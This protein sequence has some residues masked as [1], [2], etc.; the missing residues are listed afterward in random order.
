[1]HGTGEG[2]EHR[3]VQESTAFHPGD[4]RMNEPMNDAESIAMMARNISNPVEREAYIQ[5]ACAANQTLLAQVRL[6]IATP[7]QREQEHDLA[8]TLATA[9]EAAEESVTAQ[10]EPSTRPAANLI[11]GRYRLIKKIGE[12][13]M[14]SVWTAEQRQPVTRQVALKLIKKG[15]D[16]A[17][18]LARFD[19]ERQALALMDH[20]NIARIFDG[21]ITESGS[22]FFVMELVQGE[23]IT[24]FCDERRMTPEQRLELFIPVCQAIQHAHHKGII[25]R[26]IKPSNV[27]VTM[28]DD[29]PVPKVIDFGVA[30]ATGPALTDLSLD[31]GLGVV[32]TPQYM[33]PE[34]AS[35][36][37]IDIDTRS[38]V[39]SLGVLLYELLAGSTPFRQEELAKAGFLEILRVIR[40]EDPPRPSTKLSSAEALPSL[41]ASRGTDPKRLSLLLRNELDWIV[42]RSLE[43][44]RSRRYETANAFAADISRYLNGE[45][46]HAHPPS[47]GYRL[48]KFLR[49]NRGGVV[50]AASIA[51]T[52]I[53]GCIGTSL[54]MVEAQRQATLARKESIL[55]EEARQNEAQQRSIADRERELAEQRLLSARQAVSAVVN[56]IP[57][58]LEN[59]PLASG[60][61]RIILEQMNQ[62]LNATADTPE[63]DRQFASSRAWGLLAIETRAAQQAQQSGEYEVAQLHYRNA[64][65]IAQEVYQGN[66]RD[67]AKAAGNLAM[68]YALMAELSSTRSQPDSA[69]FIR[70][71]I[72]LRQEA[73]EIEPAEDSLGKRRASLGNT[74]N[75]LA[76]IRSREVSR[77]PSAEQKSA[78]LETMTIS[79]TALDHLQAAIDQLADSPQEQAI[80]RRDQAVGAI[81]LAGLAK[82]AEDGVTVIEGYELAIG[83]F[84]TLVILEPGR[85]SYRTA[86]AEVHGLYGDYLLVEK[87]DPAAARTHYVES[88]K[89]LREFSSDAQLDWLRWHRTLAYYRLGLTAQAQANNDQVRRYFERASLISDLHLREKSDLVRDPEMLIDDRVQLML[90]QAWAGQAAAAVQIARDIRSQLSDVQQSREK[91]WAAG[92]LAR[93][94]FAIA[95]ASEKGG[96]PD[97]GQKAARSEALLTMQ[98]AMDLGF[99]DVAYLHSDPDVAPLRRIEGFDALL[100]SLTTNQK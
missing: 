36:N 98:Q 14:G 51:G 78:A 48:Q 11:A 39:Y 70:E 60:P 7:L 58:L 43:K 27:L 59:V 67:R 96:L 87:L 2:K 95:I 38:D 72:Q 32:G 3:T 61:Q 54:G 50:A 62:L 16:S 28:V 89:R 63:E 88:M 25:H 18:V 82:L 93:A 53:V 85:V 80:A 10:F 92:A 12:G 31:T 90:E 45:P 6:L 22:P 83:N 74:W 30:K 55:K 77:L 100:Q 52:L 86:L 17:A 26:D 56:N 69:T 37:R 66:P 21:G 15:M 47:M 65:K 91:P 81:A 42:M 29:R 71:A 33:S 57:N 84:N 64:L 49:K 44:D 41:S 97:A 1:L 35:M 5:A 94:A 68:V 73:L 79:R 75:R 76:A 24:T 4:L 19:A 40:E 99:H 23:P 13:G 9:G 8:A 46:V 20:P 34:Q